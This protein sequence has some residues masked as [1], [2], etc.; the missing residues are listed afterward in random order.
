M[1]NYTTLLVNILKLLKSTATI[2]SLGSL[3]RKFLDH[4]DQVRAHAPH[5]VLGSVADGKESECF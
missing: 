5:A 4:D 1:T 3:Q 2:S